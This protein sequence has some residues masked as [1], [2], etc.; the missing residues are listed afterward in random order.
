MPGDGNADDESSDVL[1]DVERGIAQRL[2]DE[3]NEFNLKA[4]GIPEFHESS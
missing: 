3:I 2:I 1:S 4:T